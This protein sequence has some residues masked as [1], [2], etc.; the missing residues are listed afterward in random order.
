MIWALALFAAGVGKIIYHNDL[1][2]PHE[3]ILRMLNL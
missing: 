2:Y 1:S 3:E